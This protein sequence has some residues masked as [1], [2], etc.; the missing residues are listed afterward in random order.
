MKGYEKVR[1]SC[2]LAFSEGFEYIWIDTCCI[3]KSSSAELSEA[4]NSMF[5]W[6]QDAE[7]CYAFLSDVSTNI[8]I[9]STTSGQDLHEIT[10]S[11]W[12]S[13]GWTLQEL[14][15]PQAVHFYNREWAYL[16]SRNAAAEAIELATGITVEAL[17]G[18]SISGIS[19]YQRM[20]WASTRTTTRPEDMAYCLLGI[21]DV[22]IPLL[23]GEGKKKAFQRLQE[24]IIAKSTDLSLFLWT[25]PRDKDQGPDLEFRGLLAEDPSWFTS[26]ISGEF[27]GFDETLRKNGSSIVPLQDTAMGALNKGISVRW[28]IVPV[29]TDPAKTLHLAML[30]GSGDVTGGILIQQL[31][32]EAI[33]FCRVLS[34]KVIWFDR[35]GYTA[36]IL[37][38]DLLGSPESLLNVSLDSG[39]KSFYMSPHFDSSS[40][41]SLPGVGF[42]FTQHKCLEEKISQTEFW[43]EVESASLDF[44][45][46]LDSTSPTWVAR[47]GSEQ[48]LELLQTSQR[49]GGSKVLGALAISIKARNKQG[50][51]Q[52]SAKPNHCVVVG[53]DI[54]PQTVIGTTNTFLEPWIINTDEASP[55]DAIREFENSLEPGMWREF[56]V[57]AGDCRC[58]LRK[59]TRVSG[60]WYDVRIALEA[61]WDD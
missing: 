31:D 23:Y 3:D 20:Q 49:K 7:I 54:L 30:A 53:V 50:K 48:D 2:A 8:S 10:A 12:F 58:S 15:A 35:R 24:V 1:R 43:A 4:I 59:L 34:D 16:G 40:K 22:N 52:Y 57:C 39:P 27:Q 33:Q 51:H 29:P 6:Y 61:S 13:R 11:Q 46:D 38:H 19:I 41:P 42:S 14:I 18:Q 17:R 28:T 25:V 32:K 56:D 44:W 5:K 55:Q 9:D 45:Q 21:F 37:N 36:E 26:P 47:F 60:L